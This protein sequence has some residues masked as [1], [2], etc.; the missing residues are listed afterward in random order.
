MQSTSIWP[1]SK[2]STHRSHRDPAYKSPSFVDQVSRPHHIASTPSSDS[3]SSHE[4]SVISTA[5]SASSSSHLPHRSATSSLNSSPP[6]HGEHYNTIILPTASGSG[7]SPRTQDLL[8]TQRDLFQQYPSYHKPLPPAP[9]L[10]RSFSDWQNSL[11][12]LANQGVASSEAHPSTRQSYSNA[13][14]ATPPI[15]PPSMQTTTAAN[16]A[17]ATSAFAAPPPAA[18]H[19]KRE[20]DEVMRSPD[21]TR[22]TKS[23][24]ASSGGSKIPEGPRRE[25]TEP[26]SAL[27][28]EM[29]PTDAGGPAVPPNLA[30]PAEEGAF[31]APEASSSRSTAP[32]RSSVASSN[33][34]SPSTMASSRSSFPA[35]TSAD[36]PS[37]T[38]RRQSQPHL[39]LA[40]HPPQQLLK[41]LAALLHQ[42]ASSNDHLRPTNGQEGRDR[43]KSTWR[44]GQGDEGAQGSTT[45]SSAASTPGPEDKRHSVTTA[46][47]G[48]LGTPSSTLCFHARNIPS[49]SI[50]SYLLRILKYCP[51][52]NDV[53]LS[54]LVYFDRMSRMGVGAGPGSSSNSPAGA[55]AGLPLAD[56]VE[57]SRSGSKDGV[58]DEDRLR[59]EEDAHPGM[60][61]FVI[62]SYN[63]H[64]LVIA[65][66]TVASKFFSD[67]FY[68][69]SRY[70]KVGGLPVHELNQLELQFLLLNDFH[71]VIPLDELQRYADQLL[72]YGAEGGVLAPSRVKDVDSNT[73]ATTDA[74]GR[75]GSEKGERHTKDRGR[76][77]ALAEESAM[78]AEPPAR[79]ASGG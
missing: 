41:V 4:G 75:R 43:R 76:G 1:S 26:S 16:V 24:R 6:S 50:E 52:T 33:A 56:G 36:A 23:R 79:T 77:S 38:A 20:E 29:R 72:V 61:G 55:A 46:A 9:H 59:G 47:M 67:I 22:G 19:Q 51:T 8:Q 64:R 68:T 60:R 44:T 13:T 32:G 57:M 10:H 65:G 39:D 74:G 28:G 34:A 58:D 27:E 70:A 31:K 73:A 25:P 49:I 21:R 37:T 12:T 11:Q 3:S 15:P 78:E 2:T 40:N 69:N 17:Y 48:A 18:H 7:L 54:L 66:I 14:P 71:L 30:V 63:V 5:S 42:I 35:S 45:H 62:D 53:F